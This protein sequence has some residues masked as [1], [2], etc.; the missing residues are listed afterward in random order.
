MQNWEFPGDPVVRTQS[1][2]CQGFGFHTW[3]G[4]QDPTSFR[5]QTKK[6][7]IDKE[8]AKLSNEQSK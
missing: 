3:S 4:K 5:A 1:S 2:H 6:K 8:Q 7:K